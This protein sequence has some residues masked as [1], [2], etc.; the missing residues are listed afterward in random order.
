MSREIEEFKSGD[1]PFFN[2]MT[3]NPYGYV[4]NT[5]RSP[6]NKYAFL[7][8]SGCRHL[9]GLVEGQGPDGYTCREYIKVCSNDF[10]ALE[11]WCVEHRPNVKSF[12]GYCKTC[13]PPLPESQPINYPDDIAEHVYYLEGRAVQ[14]LVNCY[15]RSEKARADCLT[16]YGFRCAVCNMDF[17]ERYGDIGRGFMHVHHRVLLS[18]VGAG[19]EVDP[20]NDLIPV[21]PNCHSMLHRSNPPFSVE[22]LKSMLR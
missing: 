10:F 9:T 21:C 7:H 15:E 1:T 2:W 19:Y 6:N 12:S 5:G 18:S 17:E 22:E 13:K 16:H 4:L 20:V 14:V 8:R 3:N 11:N